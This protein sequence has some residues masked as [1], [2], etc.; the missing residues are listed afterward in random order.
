LLYKPFIMPTVTIRINPITGRILSFGW[1]GL[2]GVYQDTIAT[3]FH[4]DSC[5]NALSTIGPGTN[6][7]IIGNTIAVVVDP[8]ALSVALCSTRLT[9]VDD[10]TR[11]TNGERFTPTRPNTAGTNLPA[12]RF[13]YSSV[14][15]IV[16]VV[17]LHI[18]HLGYLRL[19][20]IDQAPLDTN[21]L[22]LPSAGPDTAISLDHRYLL[23]DSPIAILINAVAG[24]CRR[25]ARKH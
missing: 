11:S 12:I 4:T 17:A 18:I 19:A 24:L 6:E 21:A 23:V 15:V 14:A 13:V 20:G 25:R 9:G 8:I 2:A 5:T 7:I 22:A 10:L 16:R 1:A 3:V